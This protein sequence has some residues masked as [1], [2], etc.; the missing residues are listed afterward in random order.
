M[1]PHVPVFC[2]LLA[3]FLSSAVL[4]PCR[5]N[6]HS[7]S[8]EGFPDIGVDEKLGVQLPLDLTFSDQDG[9]AVRLGDFFTGGPVLLSLNYYSC[10]TLCPLVFR[11]L[12]RTISIVKGLSIEKDYS[13][14]TVSIDPEETQGRARAKADE[15]WRMTPG[16]MIPAGRWPF[17][18]DNKGAIDRLTA[19]V[20]FRYSR[21]GMNN[22]AHPSVL[23]VL[24]PKGKVAR[25][26]YGI[27]IRPADLRLA[28]MEAAGGKIGGSPFLNQVLLYCYHY[29]PVGKKYGLAAVSIMKISGVGMILFLAL[30]FISLWLGDK[31]K[32]GGARKGLEAGNR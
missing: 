20:G 28:L 15:T 19:S 29:D 2:L 24:T 25:Y 7:P 26:L 1:K 32:K 10:P 4:F 11:N 21:V 14:V 13:I 12:T 31:R 9:K 16:F 30:L 27:D 18:L 17:L 5:L 6:A 8:D 23:V 3:L 22:F